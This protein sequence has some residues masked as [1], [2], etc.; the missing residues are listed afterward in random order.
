VA[1]SVRVLP[2]T[3]DFEAFHKMPKIAATFESFRKEMQMIRHQAIGVRAE[4]VS[5]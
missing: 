1:G 4:G 2:A 3:L 5:G